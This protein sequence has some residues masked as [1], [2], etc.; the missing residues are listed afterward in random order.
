VFLD[1]EL[2]LDCFDASGDRQMHDRTT[3]MPFA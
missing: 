2:T 1:S 3:E